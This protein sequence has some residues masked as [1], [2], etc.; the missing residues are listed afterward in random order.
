METGRKFQIT[1]NKTQAHQL[2]E[3][4]GCQR[5]IY[6]AKVEDM[7][8]Q[9]RLRSFWKAQFPAEEAQ[10]VEFNQEYSKH[11]F[12]VDF[13][14]TVPSQILR[15]GAYRFMQSVSR[16]NK[17]LGGKP[18][19]K[20]KIGKQSVLIT[21]EL[22]KIKG[23]TL[24]IGTKKF[25]IGQININAHTE[26]STPKMICVSVDG[27]RWFVSFCNDDG[28]TYPTQ[29]EL[30][31]AFVTKPKDYLLE[32]SIGI[33]RGVVVNAYCSNGAVFVYS[34]E[35]QRA[36]KAA[37]AKKNRYQRQMSRR[38]KKGDEQQSN[39]YFRAKSSKQKA[40]RKIRNIRLDFNHKSSHQLANSEAQVIFIENLKLKNMTKAPKPKQDETGGYLPNGSAAKAGLNK[41]ILNNGLGQLIQFTEYKALRNHKLVL[42]VPAQYT[43]QKC[44]ACH[45]IEKGNRASQSVFT[46]LACGHTDNSDLNASKNI[47]DDGVVLLLSGYYHES[48]KERKKVKVG[49]NAARHIEALP[50]AQPEHSSANVEW[51]K[52]TM[53]LAAS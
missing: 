50:L 26:F 35:Q 9:M 4:I 5:Y 2:R 52:E 21:S 25:P 20:K 7:R 15:N 46:C 44:S 27:S 43:S 41:A 40:E 1:P 33:D 16:W 31:D 12:G 32:N 17:K 48:K 37:Q 45:H 29:G 47:R 13:L 34:P 28:Q 19:R 53:T 30:L 39:N 10:F 22:F 3:W 18:T 14:R 23:S 42:R 11:A 36:L 38:Y 24:F 51:H 49:R 6:N 8:Y